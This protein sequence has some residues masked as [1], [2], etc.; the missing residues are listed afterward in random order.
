M[1]ILSFSKAVDQIV[2]YRIGSDMNYIVEI[3]NNIIM[4]F[5]GLI[6]V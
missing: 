4:G 2:H 3:I 5:D 6:I 1:E